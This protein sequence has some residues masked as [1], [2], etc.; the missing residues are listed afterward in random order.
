[1]HTLSL[2]ALVGGCTTTNIYNQQYFVDP[3]AEDTADT[4]D[5]VPEVPPGETYDQV[6]GAPT[7]NADVADMT[8]DPFAVDGNVYWFG[9][10]D[11]QLTA[12]N[13]VF[14][15]GGGS[16]GY[17]YYEV[18]SSD[19]YADNLVVQDAVTGA[20][21]DYGKVQ[22]GV[23]GES[24]GMTWTP[25]S[26]PNLSVDMDEFQD[27]LSV[28]G[29]EHLR[30]NNGMI[31]SIFREALALAVF[32]ELG[33]PAPRTSFAWAA[34]P[35]WGDDTQVPYTLVESYRKDAFCV[36]HAESFGGGCAN[37]WEG[38]GEISALGTQCQ[39][40]ECDNTNY[41]ALVQVMTDN[42]RDVYGATAGKIDWGMVQ[43]HMCLDWILWIGDDPYHNQNNVVL[44]EGMDGLFRLLPYSTDISAG[45]EWYQN[46]SLYGNNSL[47]GACVHDAECWAATIATCEA[48]I[49]AFQ[50]LDPV[51]MVNDEYQRLADNGMLRDGDEDTYAYLID[52]YTTR[53]TEGV[54]EA[55]LED[56]RE[57]HSVP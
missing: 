25:T 36:D 17:Y 52:W 23:V 13:G 49:D 51:A 15:S 40:K 26:I 8:I 38:V 28:G 27:G 56:Y 9:V 32:R 11:E 24:T 14:T 47:A 1:M 57:D 39:E 30:F 41:D 3:P 54:L 7:I 35:V 4:A 29:I 19:T 18:G 46:T 43:E 34:S 10:S 31:S 20:T 42:P 6:D 53:S 50:A 16:S 55:E 33:Y 48:D 44:V 22:L 5:S 2:L 12:M 37:I 45:Q 21:A